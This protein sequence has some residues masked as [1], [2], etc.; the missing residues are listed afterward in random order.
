MSRLFVAPVTIS[1]LVHAGDVEGAGDLT[2]VV[3]L[4]LASEAAGD[5]A[6]RG[7]SDWAVLPPD[8]AGFVLTDNG[9]GNAPSYQAPAAGGFTAAYDLWSNGPVTLGWSVA[10]NSTTAMTGAGMFLGLITTTDATSSNVQGNA[11]RYFSQTSSAVDATAGGQFATDNSGE[12][13]SNSL[14]WVA[15]AF[16]TDRVTDFSF[17][18]GLVGVNGFDVVET[19]TNPVIKHVVVGAHTSRSDTNIMVLHDGGIGS[20]TRVDTGVALAK[21]LDPGIRVLVRLLSDTSAQVTIW[22]AGDDSVL[23]DATLSSDI[24]F[25]NVRNGFMTGVCPRNSGGG[26]KLNSYYYASGHAFGVA[27]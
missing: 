4:S 23:Y 22:D 13:D 12:H 5:L 19:D 10:G 14:P 15:G 25:G 26:V 27:A 21:V 7:A 11:G 24:G 17:G 20:Q 16:F 2:V 18:F 6:V 1:D 8:T 3:D 9:A